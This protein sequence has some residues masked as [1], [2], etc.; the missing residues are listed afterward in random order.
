MAAGKIRQNVPVISGF[1]KM[2]AKFKLLVWH[3]FW[4]LTERDC[5]NLFS[6][7]ISELLLQNWEGQDV[8]FK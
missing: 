8:K 5:K 4:W 1:P 6:E 7:K 3:I 2:F